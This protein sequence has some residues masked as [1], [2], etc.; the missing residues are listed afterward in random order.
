MRQRRRRTVHHHHIPAL[1]ALAVTV[2]TAIY[3]TLESV[4]MVLIVIATD[5]SSWTG[6]IIV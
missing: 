1:I 2:S 3:N 6:I 5:A 4:E